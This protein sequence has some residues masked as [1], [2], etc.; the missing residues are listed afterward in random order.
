MPLIGSTLPSSKTVDS[1]Q[2]S[3]LPKR[4]TDLTLGPIPG[5]ERTE[6]TIKQ[7]SSEQS[8]AVADDAV[9]REL[10]TI[11]AV[12]PAAAQQLVKQLQGVKPSLRALAAE[13]FRASWE[14]HRELTG[15]TSAKH[16]A[17]HNHDT[18]I[19]DQDANHNAFDPTS[20][21]PDQ[22]YPNTGLP[23]TH[24]AP[25]V[26]QAGYRPEDFDGRALTNH[27]QQMLNQEASSQHREQEQVQPASYQVAQP[28]HSRPQTITN[29]NVMLAWRDSVDRSITHLSSEVSAEP[30]STHEAYEHVRLRML[31][32][33]AGNRDAAVT[34]IPG[35]TPTE[36]NYWSNQLFALSTL[37]DHT[38]Q[39]DDEVRAQLASAQLAD[40]TSSLQELSAL[41]VK[42]LAFCTN[43]Y[44]YGDYEPF[45]KATFKPGATVKLYAEIENFRSE[46]RE[47]GYRTSLATSYEV[48]DQS[49]KRV[50]GGEFGTVD[51]NCLRKRRDF[52]IEYTFELPSR[53]YANSYELRLMVRDRLSGKIGK[54]T[55]EFEIEE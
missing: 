41:A 54:A 42:N 3:T 8:T 30:R 5:A 13:Q 48:V 19:P 31:Q 4:V 24:S 2:P 12:D 9:L 28:A 22:P 50:E 39:P 34:Q 10:S 52:Y 7:A 6:S 17:P 51:D 36:Q 37:L 21:L 49:G 46:S 35:L 32:L 44:G 20:S 53:M 29:E 1:E 25:P 16:S 11:G 45:A 38:A 18:P 27:L 15:A 14:Y 47:E 23:P 55:V 26:S 43:V 33:V 40:A